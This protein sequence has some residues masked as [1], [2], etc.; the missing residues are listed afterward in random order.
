MAS[1]TS[2]AVSAAATTSRST[3][4]GDAVDGLARIGRKRRAVPGRLD[5]AEKIVTST[6]RSNDTAPARSRS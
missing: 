1:T 5:R 3:H 2:G 6:A 4:G